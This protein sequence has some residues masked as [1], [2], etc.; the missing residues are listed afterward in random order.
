MRHRGSLRRIFKEG[1]ITYG[2]NLS[3]I[4]IGLEDKQMSLASPVPWDSLSF[5]DEKIPGFGDQEELG[6]IGGRKAAVSAY[7]DFS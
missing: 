3:S 6:E 1:I 4:S 5:Q 7:S 2:F